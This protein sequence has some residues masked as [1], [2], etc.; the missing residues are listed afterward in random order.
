MEQESHLAHLE[1]ESI[2]TILIIIINII[3]VRHDCCVRVATTY[4][5]HGYIRPAQRMQFLQKRTTSLTVRAEQPTCGAL[6]ASNSQ[7]QHT[8]KS[9]QTGAADVLKG[10]W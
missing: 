9:K 8:L 6:H 3:I 4:A 2:S 5:C 7:Q 1:P 10:L